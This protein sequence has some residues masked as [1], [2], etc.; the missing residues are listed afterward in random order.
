M[1]KRKRANKRRRVATPRQ[2]A[3]GDARTAVVEAARRTPSARVPERRRA[4]IAPAKPVRVP[5]VAGAALVGLIAFVVYAVTISPSVPTG[6]SGELISAAY[7]L[8]VAHPPGYP[9]F[10]MLGHLAALLPF[11][12]PALRVNLLSAVFDAAAVGLAFM[13]VY[14]LVTDDRRGQQN[15]APL[16]ALVAAAVG[17]LL[18][19]FSTV[20]WS[21]S[22]VAEVFALNNLFAALLLLIALEWSRRPDRVHLLW[23]FAFV[24]GLALTNQQTI[25][26]FVPAFLVLGW[27]AWSRLRRESARGGEPRRR[28]RTRDLAAACGLFIVGLLP[29][30]YLP[31]AAANNPPLNWGDPRT[32]HRFLV[33]A[34]RA[35]YGTFRL[36]VSGKSG[37]IRQQLDLLAGSLTHAFVFAGIALALLGLWWA[38]RR[39]RA[40]GLA[41]ALAFLFA[42]PIFA[43][44]TKTY[45]PDELTKGVVE[46]FYILPSV[47]L[48]ILAGAGVWQV[49]RWTSQARRPA[50]RPGVVSIAVA[51]ALLAVPVASAF[52]HYG[53]ANQ[54]GDYVAYDYGR[55]LLRPLA[56]NALL[57]MRSDENFTS[58][59]YAQEVTK[60]RPDVVALDV[61]LLKLP[62]YV[63]QMRREHPSIV[64]PFDSYDG[65]VATH[66]G[67]VVRANLAKRPVYAVGTMEEKNFAAGFQ[68]LKDGFASRIVAKGTASD[69]YELLR[70]NAAQFAA[71]HFPKRSFPSRSWENVLAEYYAGVAFDLGYALQ[72]ARTN[73][74]LAERMYRTAIRLTPTLPPPTRIWGSCSATTA[75]TRTRS[76]RSGSVSSDSTRTIRRPAR[77]GRSWPVCRRSKAAAERTTRAAQ[78]APEA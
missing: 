52:A 31:I 10:T 50:S 69:Q 21:Y 58:V 45:F 66:L 39:A 29:Y 36:T 2:A 40:E 33:D 41:L 47:P 6:D 42:G 60:F 1:A 35:N 8:G 5:A 67:D 44:Y 73:A 26:L 48:A 3:A 11:G 16:A 9:L 68:Q 15:R 59:S 77:S 70:R 62:T 54:R 18:L 23:A 27:S 64:I 12:S 25:L 24:F 14:R 49:L 46:R 38:W 63:A 7:V 57:L 30:A 20:F 4:E 32:L 56:P 28:P 13:V 43:A 17:S 76:S 74:P 19:A 37:S 51:V 34:R 72:T 78:R 22:V 55:D 75:A 53:T 65:G 71:Y 61:E